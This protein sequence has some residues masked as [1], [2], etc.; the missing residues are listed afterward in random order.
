MSSSR[1]GPGGRTSNGGGAVPLAPGSLGRAGGRR[2]AGGGAVNAGGT[3]GVRAGG[4]SSDGGGFVCC[5]SLDGR[6]GA[7][8]SV[9]GGFVCIGCSV[10]ARRTEPGVTIIGGRV[11]E[12]RPSGGG[13][14]G[15]RIGGSVAAF[16]RAGPSLSS[17]GI[18]ATASAESRGF[19][20]SSRA[21]FAS[22]ANCC[23]SGDDCF[24]CTGFVTRRIR[25]S[26]SAGSASIS[27]VLD[28][29]W[30]LP[31]G[32]IRAPLSAR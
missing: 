22:T 25:G 20:E 1:F 19:T 11:G 4:R 8:S 3:L 21:F 30:P 5:G 23:A 10:G 32:A 16:L 13:A 26:L 15:G 9:G 6:A 12:R 29:C 31:C 7:R 27:S 18:D 17:G 24:P 28:A 2:F 14:V